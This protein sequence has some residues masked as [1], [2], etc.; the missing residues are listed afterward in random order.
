MYPAPISSLTTVHENHDKSAGEPDL[1]GG[2]ASRVCTGGRAQ[3]FE[4]SPGADYRKSASLLSV[5]KY[6]QVHRNSP[7]GYLSGQRSRVSRAFPIASRSRVPLSLSGNL[8]RL[9]ASRRPRPAFALA[10]QS[11][12]NY[13]PRINGDRTR[14]SPRI[15]RPASSNTRPSVAGDF[16]ARRGAISAR[17]LVDRASLGVA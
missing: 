10:I 3:R 11:S 13:H 1:S 16:N 6:I 4:T 17:S 15:I 9:R 2:I 12:A 5:P 7:A 8:D 14:I